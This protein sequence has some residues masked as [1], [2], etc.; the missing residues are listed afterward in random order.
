MDI[1]D[2]QNLE[3]GRKSIWTFFIRKRLIAFILII[4]ISVVGLISIFEIPKE[5]MP[6]VKIPMAIIATIVPG[7]TPTD[8]EEL[9]TNPVEKEVAGVSDIADWASS[10]TFGVSIISVQFEP[11]IDTKEAISKLKDA[12]EKTSNLP[13]TAI[14]PEVTEISFT[15]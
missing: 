1:I 10:S 6:E 3:K 5:A 14:G 7:A 15:N 13:D 12:V 8:V 4:G 2:Q 11:N 9:V